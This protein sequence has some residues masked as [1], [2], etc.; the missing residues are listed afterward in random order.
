VTQNEFITEL[1]YIRNVS[2]NTLE[3]YEHAFRAF[4][5]A[6]ANRAAVVARIA[7]LREKG[8]SAVSVNTYLRCLNAYFNWLHTQHQQE[9][10]RIPK[11]KEPQKLIETLTPD[12]VS[13]VVQ[14]RPKGRNE[15]RAR[16]VALTALDTGMRIQELLD[17]R[18]SDVDLDNLSFKG[19]GKRNK[20]RLVPMSIELRKLLFRHLSQHQFERVIVTLRGTSPTQRN[21]FRDFQD[22][23]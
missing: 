20:Y 15:I 18:R 12:Q 19:H 6:T 8:L 5:N 14:D 13:R 16:V 1:K 21:L 2:A 11:L 22:V 9:R 3:L 7:Q 10:I 23:V 17:L 4:S